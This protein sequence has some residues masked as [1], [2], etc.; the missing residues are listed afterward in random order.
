LILAVSICAPSFPADESG[1]LSIATYRTLHSEILKEERT[2][3][4]SVPHDYETSGKRYPV[5]YVLDAEYSDFAESVGLV[6]FLGRYRI[7]EMIVIGVA[8]TIRNKDLWSHRIEGLPQTRDDGAPN[9]SRFFSEELI[10]YIDQNYR[11]TPHRAI[12]G[13]SAA[14][15]FVIFCLLNKPELFD[16]YLASSPVIGFSES[17]LLAEAESFF[18]TRESLAKSLFVYYGDTDYN[19]VVERI[20]VLESILRAKA[21]GDFRWGVKRVEGRHGPPESLQELLLMLYPAWKPVERP[22]IQPS[23][24]E[25]LEGE[26]LSVEISHGEDPVHFTLNGD[27]PTRS[28]PVYESPLSITK[29]STVKAKAVRGDLQ[30]SGTVS[31]DFMVAVENRPSRPVSSLKAGLS[32]LYSEQQLF[33]TPDRMTTSIKKSGVV[34]TIDLG[35]RE[36]NQFYQLQFEGFIQVPASGRYRFHFTSVGGKLFIDDQR[37]P[38]GHGLLP[39]ETVQDLCLEEGYHSIRIVSSILTQPTNVLGL[40]WEGPGIEKQEIPPHAFWHRE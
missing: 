21:P 25:L 18:G 4:V 28:S 24:G 2:V 16:D 38:S 34:P 7:P 39:S 32:Y 22:V 23:K 29:T 31:A 5:L 37:I 11:T 36:R 6:H 12:Y 27:E 10:P 3:A 30:E 14:G 35:V 17:P 15:H 13:R 9:F 19:S 26:T 20:P 1:Q 40:E 8:N 33:D